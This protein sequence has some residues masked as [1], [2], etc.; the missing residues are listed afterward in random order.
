M[1]VLVTGVAGFI[2]YHVSKRLLEKK[3][4]VIG[5]DNLNSYYDV[6]LK[7]D[8][9][10]LLKKNKLE[11]Y[12]IDLLEKNKINKLLKTYKFDVIINLAAQAGVRYSIQ[13]PE[14]YIDNNINGFFNILNASKNYKVKHFIYA[15]SSSVY[16]KNEKKNFSESDNTDE[17]MSI[18]AATKKC[19]EVIAHSYSHIYGIPTT[20]LRFFTA[21]GPFG[22]PDMSLFIF[23]KSILERKKINIFNYGKMYRDFTFVDDVANS[24]YKLSQ[25]KKKKHSFEIFNISNFKRISLMK[26]IFVIE[27]YLKIKSLKN[28]MK[29]QKGDVKSTL[30]N[31][32]KIFK[33]IKFKPATKLDVGISKFISWYKSYF[34]V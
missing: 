3:I 12:K 8:R 21:Y 32:K 11:F 16:G 22:R 9:L 7:K 17:P 15:S 5:I 28:Y 27:K 20:G 19:N 24:I 2:G 33:S 31:N 14:T 4:K 25:L 34:D 26:Y 23:T 30:G 29:I 1:K 13:C 6:K 18:Y 10:R